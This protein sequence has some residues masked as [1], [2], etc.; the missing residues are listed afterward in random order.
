M[1][2]ESRTVSWVILTLGLDSSAG[3]CRI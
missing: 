3:L 1:K 2:P